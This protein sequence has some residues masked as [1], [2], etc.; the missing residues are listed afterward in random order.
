LRK[1]VNF[2]GIFA[3]W[4]LTELACSNIILIDVTRSKWSTITE[5]GFGRIGDGCAELSAAI[6]ALICRGR[7]HKAI[8]HGRAKPPGSGIHEWQGSSDG[9]QYGHVASLEV[10]FYAVLF[11]TYKMLIITS[12]M[13]II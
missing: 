3:K 10:P 4:M 7:I 6:F 8:S 11:R 5:N 2:L 1:G 13:L 12:P 9:P